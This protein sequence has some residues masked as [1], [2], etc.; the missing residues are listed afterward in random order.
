MA[1]DPSGFNPHVVVAG[2]DQSAVHTDPADAK[3][4]ST[5]SSYAL[6]GVATTMDPV[7]SFGYVVD[8]GRIVLLDLLDPKSYGVSSNDIPAAELALPQDAAGRY[9][10]AVAWAR[11]K[12]P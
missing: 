4:V 1:V 6:T 7:N 12:L 5:P 11:S 9:L 3:P 2:Y 10:T 8:N